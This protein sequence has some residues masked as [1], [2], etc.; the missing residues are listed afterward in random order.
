MPPDENLVSPK[1][2]VS[3]SPSELQA[4]FYARGWTDGL[5]VVRPT[6]ERVRRMLSGCRRDPQE[7]VAVLPPKMG[8][9]TMEKL[10]V[11][12]VMA[13][14]LPEYLPVLVAAVEAVAEERFNL[15]GVQATTH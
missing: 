7:V 9:A 15:L 10:A 12:A 13:G 8:R 3:D 6:E 14:C 5:P 1:I 2:K 11:N 4:E